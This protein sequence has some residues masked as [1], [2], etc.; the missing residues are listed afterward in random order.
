VYQSGS[1]VSTC[2]IASLPSCGMQATLTISCTSKGNLNIH[3]LAAKERMLSVPSI[4]DA[5]QVHAMNNA[6]IFHCSN[7]C[8]SAA[9]ICC[10]LFMYQWKRWHRM[11]LWFGGNHMVLYTQCF[12]YFYQ[13]TFELASAVK[14]YHFGEAVNQ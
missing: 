13:H 5:F 12:A 6:L 14:N 10:T 1:I 8:M 11:S 4:R 9:L 7:G 3:A 2:C